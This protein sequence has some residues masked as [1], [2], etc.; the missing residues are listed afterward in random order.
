MTSST[1]WCY[2][3]ANLFFSLVTRLIF[4]LTEYRQSFQVEEARAYLPSSPRNNQYSSSAALFLL[5]SSEPRPMEMALFLM[6][7]A[8]ILPSLTLS[9]FPPGMCSIQNQACQAHEDNVIDTVG[10]VGLGECKALCTDATDCQF[11]SYFGPDS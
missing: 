8:A 11:I 10:G 9:S 6:L 5:T 1:K 3:I 4:S 2:I 7:A